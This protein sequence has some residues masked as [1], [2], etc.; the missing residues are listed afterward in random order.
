MSDAPPSSERA[1][2]PRRRPLTVV[3][4]SLLA[5][6]VLA[7][8]AAVLL[9]GV[10]ARQALEAWLR[11]RGVDAQVRIEGLGPGG[12]KGRVV[13]GDAA[14]P[15][16][17]VGGVELDYDL[18][19]PWFGRPAGVRVRAVR[20][21]DVV[22]R[23]RLKDGA[24]SFG[25]LDRLI[26]ELSA[27][28]A[29][30]PAPLPDIDLQ[31][32]AILLTTEAGLLRLDGSGVVK[33]GALQRF[34]GVVAP[35]SLKAD[36][37]AAQIA[38][39]RITARRR[40]DDLDLSGGI[41]ASE[42]RFGE[43]AGT[44]LVIDLAA[45]GPLTARGFKGSARVE[46][47]AG[48]LRAGER[49]LTGAHLL[50]SAPTLSVVAADGGYRSAGAASLRLSADRADLGEA[51]AAGLQA[52][53]TVDRH[54]GVWGKGGGRAQATWLLSGQI[55]SLAAAEAELSN[56]R[57][58]AVGSAASDA[59][60][61]LTAH[62][63]LSSA[64]RLTE[65]GARRWAASLPI[66]AQEPGYRQAFLAAAR[67]FRLEA[68][69]AELDWRQG[70][71]RLELGRAASLRA[72]SGARLSIAS[73]GDAPVFVSR[74]AGALDAALAGGG[75]P[76]LSA[77][78]ADWRLTEG[79]L[80]ARGRVRGAFDL[81]PLDDVAVD[82]AGRLALAGGRTTFAA[83]RCLTLSVRHVELDANDLTE[84]KGQACPS[85]APMFV[86][87]GAAWRARGAFRA[88][89][90]AAPAAEGRVRNASGRFDLAASAGTVTLAAADLID[91]AAVPRFAPLRLSGRA[92]QRGQVWTASAVAGLP[93]GPQLAS[94]EGR[95]DLARGVGEA[96]FDTGLLDFAEGG[97]QAT[98][99]TPMAE[100]AGRLNGHARFQGEANWTPRAARSSG[101]LTLDG[102]DLDTP[103][104]RIAG[105]R[106]EVGFASLAPLATLPDQQLRADK[107]AFFTPLT[108]LAA[109]FTLTPD[110][111]RLA[112]FTA[113]AA[114]GRVLLD[115]MSVALPAGT[116]E[117][118]LTLDD[119][120]LNQVV[121]AT[122]LS[123][124]IRL[125]AVV[126]GRLPFSFGPQGLRVA[127]GRLTSV[128]PGRVYIN[129]DILGGVS[130]ESSPGAPPPQSVNAIQDFA[131][132][133]MEN[134]AFE[135]LT[136][137]VSSRDE[138][139]LG[140]VFQ[141]KGRHDPERAERARL[142]ILDVLRGRAF[143]RRIPLPKG[144]PIDLTLDTSLNF[145]ELMQAY[146]DAWR[147]KVEET[148]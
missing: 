127:N 61:S 23:A 109:T 32:G 26:E 77:E 21:R 142:S 46:A 145:D 115:P 3:L 90:F 83:D 117:G 48:G 2:A 5:L 18:V 100:L 45:R 146:A 13:L 58:E 105:A 66:I 137:E 95:H 103:A 89:A 20:L 111:L 112:S 70:A 69:A 102:L 65:A 28:P 24:L 11:E 140:L 7:A 71:A 131:Y 97:F 39:G 25:R 80:S 133:A 14:R 6:L 91:T 73:H 126:D 123:E 79:G 40:G 135:T 52:S 148:P 84:V 104:G 27:R 106:G 107:L 114:G 29:G 139:R 124:K 108:D 8:L 68:P 37:L 76:E 17:S 81:T 118:V 15:D 101:R 75:M 22:V 64:G 128:H 116:T 36:G 130:A 129:R 10:I 87:E 67:G 47:A 94:A 56:V 57:L 134:L 9:R 96:R 113:Q 78:V 54:T 31:R 35:A 34:D 16:L 143:E 74:G 60:G 53:A 41:R 49:R 42:A 125:N 62:G 59:G 136:A 82:A 92:V 99:V 144:T 19:A 72:S 43:L 98:S 4:A 122:N 30:E 50:A 119:V 38:G 88:V 33:D 1:A 12:A 85:G 141:I 138:G 44:G 63:S 93:G 120:D 110:Q 51:V 121:A 132:Q 86:A 147:R 55:A